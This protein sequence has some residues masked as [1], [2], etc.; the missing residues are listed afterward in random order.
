MRDKVDPKFWRAANPVMWGALATILLIVLAA[1]L[2]L[3]ETCRIDDQA[4]RHCAPRWQVFW[5]SPPNEI[6]DTLAG[7][8]GTLAFIW[9]LVTVAMQAQDLRDTREDTKRMAEAF[10]EQ[11]DFFRNERHRRMV[12]ETLIN[13]RRKIPVAD[14]RPLVWRTA[15]ADGEDTF[16]AEIAFNYSLPGD[17]DRGRGNISQMDDA[18]FLH[19]AYGAINKVFLIRL[20]AAVESGALRSAPRSPVLVEQLHG[21]FEE[22]NTMA[23]VLPGDLCRLLERCRVSEWQSLLTELRS[24][25]YWRIG[26]E[27]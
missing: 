9:L 14:F 3:F 18:E 17:P 27:P 21:L 4:I 1:A 19:R 15:P 5:H 7:F 23:A 22:L 6:G 8:A 2:A 20:K 12:N 26:A 24:A 25:A 16:S 10:N 11:A 13:I